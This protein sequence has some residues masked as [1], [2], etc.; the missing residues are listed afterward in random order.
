MINSSLAMDIASVVSMGGVKSKRKGGKEG[1]IY[2]LAY[3]HIQLSRIGIWWSP[4]VP[5]PK[6]AGYDGGV[7]E[8]WNE[9]TLFEG[10]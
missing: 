1:E 9:T 4:L 2:A 10:C 3:R 8:K 5:L 7:S 6:Q